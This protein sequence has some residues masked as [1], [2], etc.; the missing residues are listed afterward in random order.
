MNPVS[1]LVRGNYRNPIKS[2]T[3]VWTKIMRKAYGPVYRFI[4]R[5]LAL[6]AWEKL[7]EEIL[8]AS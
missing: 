4:F 6:P 5:E 2:R 8:E 1:N 7:R 3:V